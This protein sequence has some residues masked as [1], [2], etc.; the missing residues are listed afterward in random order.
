M[1][2]LL[3]LRTKNRE[4]AATLTK[5]ADLLDIG[6]ANPF[7]IRAYRN[8]SRL[9]ANLNRSVAEMVEHHEPL[10]ELPGIGRDLAGKISE[11][12]HTGDLTL[13]REIEKKTPLSLSELMKIPSLGPKKIQILHQRLHV[14]DLNDLKHA[15][16][17]GK[18]RSLPRFG[19]KTE[20][21]LLEEIARLE[22]KKS[23]RMLLAQAEE[24]A[25]PILEYLHSIDGVQKAAIGG[26]YRRRRD[27]VGDLDIVVTCTEGSSVMEDFVRMPNV[28]RI[29]AHG[30]KRSTIV[31]KSGLQ[32]DIRVVS[33]SSFES[34]LYYF[35]GSKSHNIAMRTM[36]QKMGLKINEYGVF[37]K[38]K[39][40]AGRT[41]EEIFKSVGLTYIE[42]ELRENQGEIEAAKRGDLPRLI[43]LQDIRG[44]LHVHTRASDGGNSIEE[45]ANAARSRG[46][47]YMAVTDHTKNLAVTHG[48][49]ARRLLAQL[50]EIEKLNE[51]FNDFVVLKSAE[52]DILE[53][54]SLDLPEYVLKKLDLTVCSIHSKFNLTRQKQT[55]RLLRAMDSPYF[56][57][58]GH[59]SGRLLGERAPMAFDFDRILLAARE[60]NICLELNAQP[61]RLDLNDIDSRKA[62]DLGVNIVISTDAHDLRSL[63]YMKYG[64]GQARRGWLEARNVVN[65]RP[66]SEMKM[67][68]RSMN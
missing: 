4:V 57:V 63:D 14:S 2:S 39:K 46:Y 38:D 28:E 21:R 36:A 8:A 52:V 66:F 55:D 15:L 24:A 37:R 20:T 56:T 9:I 17:S 16:I 42:P 43:E 62:K 23:E 22:D 27:T 33:K 7:R 13:L 58:W 25:E 68:L 30:P 32:I 11:I 54:G 5:V 48:L 61:Q 45:M 59:P 67:L 12:V 41:E 53:D 10:D 50:H 19:K 64:V 40:I 44:D 1:Q 3:D 34:A 26:S 31:L 18:V 6:G 35:T 29:L 65:T 49:D 60:R 47:A 51:R